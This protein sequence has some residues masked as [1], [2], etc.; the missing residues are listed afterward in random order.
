VHY[1]NSF[2]PEA[3]LQP[4]SDHSLLVQFGGSISLETHE[5]V[6]SLTRLL[7]N[8]IRASESAPLIEQ[9]ILNL[10][11]GYTS[12]LITFN[13]LRTSHGELTDAVQSLLRQESAREEAADS[14]TGRHWEIPVCYGG[15]FGPDLAEVAALHDLSEKEVIFYHSRVLYRV[16]FLGFAPGFPYLGGL[17]S[18]L[19]TPRLETP[20][21]HVPAG[22]VAIGGEQTGIYS[23][24]SPGGWRIIGQTPHQLFTPGST[25]PTLLSAGD[26][27]RFV[28]ISREAWDR[29]IYA[30]RAIA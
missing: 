16:Y 30:G 3:R 22:S 28:P 15:E 12:L 6:L 19:A 5:Q 8:S 17:P 24:D 20:R 11:P 9:K 13:P 1:N 7:Q 27:L 23:V 14:E 2:M 10:H 26:T 29:V 18:R 25:E 21:K 4:A